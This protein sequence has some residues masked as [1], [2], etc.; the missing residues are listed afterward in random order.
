MKKVLSLVLVIAMVLSSMS[1][2]FA[3]TFEDVTGDYEDAINALAGLGVVTGY[4]DGT[5]RPE[6]VVTRAEMAKLMVEILGYGDLVAGA[7][8]N[9]ADTQGHWADAY[10]A[11]AAGRNIVVGDGNGNFRPDA[12][13]TY[14]EV[15]TMIV[16]GLGY[17]DDSNEIKSMTWPT[18]FKVKAAELGITDGVKMSTTGADRGGVAQALYNALEASLVSVNTDGDVVYLKGT[19]DRTVP[20]LSR[21]A[22]EAGTWNDDEDRYEFTVAP[23]HLDSSDKDYAGD[24]VDLEPYMYQTVEAYASKD[25]S[26]IIVYVGDNYSDTVEGTFVVD[27]NTP[28]AD[29]SEI[30]VK[31]ADGTVEDLD[32]TSAVNVY[33]NGSQVSLDES[34][35]EDGNADVTVDLDDAKVVVILDDSDEVEAMVA[36]NATYANRITRTYKEDAIKLGQIKLPLK[37]DE[38]NLNKV[39]VTGAVDDIYDIEEDDIVVAYAA[40]GYDNDNTN[41]T[42]VAVELVVVRDT[43]EGKV[44]EVNSTGS[45][46]Y[47][48]NVKYTRSATEGRVDTFDVGNEGTFFLD[49]AG[50]LFAKEAS[51]ESNAKDYAVV[52]EAYNGVKS[53]SPLRTIADAE[54]KIINAAGEVVTYEV[55]DDTYYQGGTNTSTNKVIDASLAFVADKDGNVLDSGALVKIKVDEDGI[56]TKVEIVDEDADNDTTY[57][58][59]DTTKSSFNVADSAPIF[60]IAAQNSVDKNDY[61]VIDA[62]DLPDSIKVTFSDFNDDGEYKVIVS[63]NADTSTG[64]FALITGVNYVLND[65]DVKVAKITAYVDGVK[66]TYLGEDDAITV[67]SSAIDAGVIVNLSLTSGEVDSSVTGVVSPLAGVPANA[68]ISKAIES[69]ILV[70]GTSYEQWLNLSDEVVVYVV[71]S[72][73]EFEAVGSADDLAGYDVV[74]IYEVDADEFG[75]DIVIVK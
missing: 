55:D 9:F 28:A 40:K 64:T 48:D 71:N 36:F 70:E 42:T 47:I 69:R 49:D 46:V 26:D 72:D 32:I 38:V 33:Y 7:K 10:I 27:S 11:L 6:K 44:T 39:T 73:N 21:I 57:A 3:S 35:M 53:G 59:V 8:S 62:S 12:T 2:A 25:D 22:Q 74:G 23:K 41:I 60:N 16:R 56:V 20:L 19:G 66:T 31:L 18:N 45:T 5:Y 13:V 37:G 61:S 58:T 15:L 30:Q 65:D 63:T 29:D 43:V 24:I 14:N 17:T 75:Y 50:K 67:T 51:T 4:E 1:F 52:I 54:I 68:Y 34:D